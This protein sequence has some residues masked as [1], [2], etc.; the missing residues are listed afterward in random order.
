MRSRMIS[1]GGLL[2]AL[3]VVIMLLGGAIGIG[4][5]AGPMLAMLVLLPLQEEYGA[6]A[7]LPAWF[8]V[9][10]I[11]LLLI[12]DIE[13]AF[14]YTAFGWYPTVQPTLSRLPGKLLPF[15]AKLGIYTAVTLALYQLLLR[16]LGLTADLL[17]ST[18]LFNLM[19]FCAG[20][21]VFLLMDRMLNRFRQIWRTRFRD[22]F[23]H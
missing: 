6:K 3:A 15:L 16:L 19:L 14:V 17:E 23:F 7:A 22:R 5:Y 9:S 1:L 4:T 20:L 2:V 8:A 18:R 12:P 11:S 10:V 21:L 13:L